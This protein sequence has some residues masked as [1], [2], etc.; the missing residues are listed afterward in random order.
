MITGFPS[1]DSAVESLRLGVDDYIAKPIDPRILLKIIE[2]KLE[3][4]EAEEITLKALRETL[5]AEF[6]E[7]PSRLGKY[8]SPLRSIQKVVKKYHTSQ[9]KS[10]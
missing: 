9:E 3:E 10:T 7:L 4:Q 6:P 5:L 8:Q 1:V 2:E